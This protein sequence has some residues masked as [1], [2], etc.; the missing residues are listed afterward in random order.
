MDGSVYRLGVA[1]HELENP[2][3]VIGVGDSWILQPEDPWEITGYVHNVVF[4]CGAVPESDGTVKI[5]WGG[6][7]TVMC[8][9]EANVSDLVALCLHHGRPAK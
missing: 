6:A 5:Y 1:L 7:D 3:K 4:T 8:V 9:G 2:A